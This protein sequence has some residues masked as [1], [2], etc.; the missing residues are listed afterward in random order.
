MKIVLTV[1]PVHK[2]KDGIYRLYIGLEDSFKYFKERQAMV[3]LYL[4]EPDPICV[5]TTCGINK[6]KDLIC[7]VRKLINGLLKIILTNT[8]I[9]IQL[10]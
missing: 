5:K 9:E 7:Q 2:K 8:S 3:C 4:D 6:K 10:N 1:Q